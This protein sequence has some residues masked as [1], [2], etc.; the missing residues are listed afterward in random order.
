MKVARIDKKIGIFFRWSTWRDLFSLEDPQLCNFLLFLDGYCSIEFRYAVNRMQFDQ[1]ASSY[2]AVEIGLVSKNLLKLIY[3]TI[4]IS[5]SN[6]FYKNEYTQHNWKKVYP[7]CATCDASIVD[8][9][10]N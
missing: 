8:Q 2:L 7:V 9:N 10:N 6:L 1:I 4:S 5:K 3:A